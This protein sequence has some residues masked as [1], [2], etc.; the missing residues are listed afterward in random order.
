[1]QR[2]EQSVDYRVEG[3]NNFF[4]RKDTDWRD[5][6][7]RLLQRMFRIET[8]G[9]TLLDV[10]CGLGDGLRLM[11]Q[12]MR[13]IS[14]FAGT[15]FSDGAI[16]KNSAND[17]LADIDF[18]VHDIHQPLDRMYDN[19]ICLQTL[20]HLPAPAEA[21]TNLIDA[22]NGVLI[23][24]SPYKNRRPDENHLWSF[25]ESDFA[26][27]FETFLDKRNRNIFWVL[28]KRPKGSRLRR[29]RLPLF[30]DKLVSRV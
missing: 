8:L 9:G 15:D 23:A 6:D 20:E 25:D 26:D 21:M 10:G 11:Q 1:M 19:I 30:I 22:T 2:I 24:A 27:T 12:Q 17:S 28:D 29:R 4:A 14:S 5:K 16:H 7:Y 18:F 13:R 3:W